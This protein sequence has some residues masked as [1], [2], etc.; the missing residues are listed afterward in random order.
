VMSKPAFNPIALAVLALVFERPMHPYEMVAMLKHRQ[1]HE[2]IELRYGTLYTAID[3]L[4]LRGL[5]RSQA[6]RTG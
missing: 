5:I 1:K 6:A 3:R 4:A 2:S